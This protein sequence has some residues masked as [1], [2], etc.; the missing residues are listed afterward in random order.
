VEA[1]LRAATFSHSAFCEHSIRHHQIS[2][3][4]TFDITVKSRETPEEMASRLKRE[5]A[6]AAHD[7]RKDFILFLF[8]LILVTALVIFSLC[9][10]LIQDTDPKAKE[11]AS[12]IIASLLGGVAGYFYGKSKKD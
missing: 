5:E 4:S 2:A 10:L 3:D 11:V 9:A 7:R 12:M 8:T 6:Q 1:P